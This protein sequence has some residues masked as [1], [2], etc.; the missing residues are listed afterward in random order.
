MACNPNN[1]GRIN[2]DRLGRVIPPAQDRQME[3]N[4]RFSFHQVSWR[5]LARVELPMLALLTLMFAV[6]ALVS[7]DFELKLTGWSLS[8]LYTCPFFFLTGVPCLLCGMTRSFL[9]M[10]SLDAG[11]AFIF[12]PL[13][14]IIF[15]L[16]AGLAVFLVASVASRRRISFSISPELRRQLIVWGTLVVLAAWVV[17]IIVW[18]KTGLI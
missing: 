16:L 2:L 7:P 4:S 8:P 9:A 12:H 5:N 18:N 14:P 10:G 15:V 11:Q 3:K 6:S 17:K 13:G 1:I